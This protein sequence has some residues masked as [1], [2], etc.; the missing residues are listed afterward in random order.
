MPFFVGPGKLGS[1]KQRRLCRAFKGNANARRVHSQSQRLSTFDVGNAIMKNSETALL[2]NLEET[3]PHDRGLLL[4]E[5]DFKW[6][7]AGEGWS[8]DTSHFHDDPA[9]AAVF[10]QLALESHSQALRQCAASLQ[11]QMKLKPGAANPE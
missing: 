5:V 10:L 1:V 8:I 4:A 11:T 2:S 6:L 3:C 9:Q 7:M